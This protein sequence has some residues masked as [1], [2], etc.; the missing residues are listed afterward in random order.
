MDG[1]YR[2]ISTKQVLLMPI[3]VPSLKNLPSLSAAYLC[4]SQFN[5]T[6]AAVLSLPGVL[7][8]NFGILGYSLNICS[9]EISHLYMEQ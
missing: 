1:R 2:H 6:L 8:S 4:F 9:F 5:V 7:L 3:F